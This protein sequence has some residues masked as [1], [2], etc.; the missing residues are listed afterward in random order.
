M[1]WVARLT[2]SSTKEP[3]IQTR[4]VR[5]RHDHLAMVGEHL[6]QHAKTACRIR[7]ML[8]HLDEENDVER[9]EVG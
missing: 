1:R 8:D 9:L 6:A 4:C 7:Q 3:S 5:G 2:P